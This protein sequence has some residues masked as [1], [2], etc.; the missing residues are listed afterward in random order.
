MTEED[1]RE[2][3]NAALDYV[4]AGEEYRQKQISTPVFPNIVGDTKPYYHISPNTWTTGT[5]SST[6]GSNT[7][8]SHGHGMTDKRF[9]SSITDS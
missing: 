4:E 7:N 6:Y 1:L 9:L 3:L 8:S 5:W 2:L